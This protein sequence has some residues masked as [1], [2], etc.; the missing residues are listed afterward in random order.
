MEKFRKVGKRSE[1]HFKLPA[2]SNLSYSKKLKKIK[3]PTEIQ[4]TKFVFQK[5]V[6]FLPFPLLHYTFFENHQ[7]NFAKSASTMLS[8]EERDAIIHSVHIEQ[9]K[10]KH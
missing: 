2:S 6:I 8:L 3:K 1:N 5:L 9:Q 10:S 7:H 4:I